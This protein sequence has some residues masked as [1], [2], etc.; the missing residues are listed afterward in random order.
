MKSSGIKNFIRSFN[1]FELVWLVSVIV[2][3]TVF[4]SLFP[5]LM[6]EDKEDTLVVIC[7]VVSIVSSPICEILIS[8]QCRYWTLFSLVFVEITDIIIL[9]NLKLYSSALISLFFWIPFDILTFFQWGGKNRDE[10][11]RELTKVK[12]FSWRQDIWIALALSLGG[13]LL[14]GVLSSVSSVSNVYAVAYSNVF[15]IANGIFLLIRHNEQWLA[16]LGYLVCESIIW[17]SLG[18]YIML[19]TVFAMMINTVYGFIKW[20]LYIKRRPQVSVAS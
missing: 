14:G 18:H 19:I 15:E 12:T 20:L 7:S 13:L 16:W 2:L 10:E 4:I 8:K 6:F 11:K 9:L 5:D 3:L 17:I 1:L